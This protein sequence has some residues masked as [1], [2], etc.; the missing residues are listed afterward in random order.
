MTYELKN[1]GILR[2]PTL[3]EVQRSEAEEAKKKK[4]SKLPTRHMR[5]IV[6]VF[7]DGRIKTFSSATAAAQ[8]LD[9]L[10]KSVCNSCDKNHALLHS[11]DTCKVVRWHRAGGYMVFDRKDFEVI[12]KTKLNIFE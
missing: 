6:V 2:L 4:V 9:C 3:S 5:Q 10:L 8:H 7:N 11:L 12:A 1:Y